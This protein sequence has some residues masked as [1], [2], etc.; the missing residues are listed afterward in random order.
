MV[1]PIGPCFNRYSNIMSHRWY[2]VILF[3]LFF[4]VSA[5]DSRPAL[6]RR[7]SFLEKT[8]GSV[9]EERCLLLGTRRAK[10][11]AGYF[12]ESIRQR[13]IEPFLH[14]YQE[15][16]LNSPNVVDVFGTLVS[17]DDADSAQFIFTW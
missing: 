1:S 12:V 14:I 16:G 2:F 11:D 13:R 9:D 15:L 17:E 3:C 7:C 5:S 10:T 6:K 8:E 4:A